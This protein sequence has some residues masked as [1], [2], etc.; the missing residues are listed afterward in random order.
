MADTLERAARREGTYARRVGSDGR[1]ASRRSGGLPDG[2]EILKAP[3]DPTPRTKGGSAH[4]GGRE[5][6]E[7]RRYRFTRNREDARTYIYIYVAWANSGVG[8]LH[9]YLI[10]TPRA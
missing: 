2:G 10:D 7:E 4:R 1:G 5:F 6:G 9:R 8:S 3:V